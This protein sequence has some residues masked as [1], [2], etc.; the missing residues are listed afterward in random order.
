MMGDPPAGTPNKCN[1]EVQGSKI[2]RVSPFALLQLI[3][4]ASKP[5]GKRVRHVGFDGRI[6]GCPLNFPFEGFIQ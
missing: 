3:P 1:D 5:S 6:I 4:T 2:V